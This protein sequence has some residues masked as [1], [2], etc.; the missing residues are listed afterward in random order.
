MKDNPIEG[1]PMNTKEGIETYKAAMGIST[2]VPNP[3]I[4]IRQEDEDQHLLADIGN[5]ENVIE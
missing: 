2:T 1:V 5:N 3:P 4:N